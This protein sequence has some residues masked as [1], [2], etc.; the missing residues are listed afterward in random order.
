VIQAIKS[1]AHDYL[2]KPIDIDELK[3]CVKNILQVEAGNNKRVNKNMMELHV[4]D[5]II[6]IRFQ[7][8]IRLEASGSYTVFYLENQVK[9][10]ASKN[11]KECETQLD[12]T[13]FYRCHPSHIINLKKV[14]K[15][16]STD[17]LFARMTDGSMPEI[18]RKNKDQFLERLKSV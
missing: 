18:V 15:M 14:E 6:F 5:G 17:G 13:L 4:K 12:P 2:L 10:I 16:V 3:N 1:R 11:L 7:D 9:H 8:I